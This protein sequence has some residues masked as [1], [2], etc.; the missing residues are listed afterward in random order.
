MHETPRLVL[1]ALGLAGLLVLLLNSNPQPIQSTWAP[2]NP[3]LAAQTRLQTLQGRGMAAADYPQG[4]PL[5]V[6]NTVMTQ[7][8]GVG[9]HAPA[10]T[11]GAVDLALDGDG[12]GRADPRASWNQPIYATHSGVIT[13]TA[14][15]WPAGNH[16]WVTNDQYRTGYAHLAEFA[17]TDGQ[18]VNP[19]DLIGYMGSS[20]QSSG[21]HLD[22]QIWAWQAGRWVNQ[23]PLDYGVLP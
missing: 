2:A 23:N 1:I 13:T 9:S 16:V 11:W 19:G 17:V 15:S 7:G 18:V 3:G 8:Y 14:N 4:N 22:Y 6:L 21:P 10:A 20:G 5:G 12:D